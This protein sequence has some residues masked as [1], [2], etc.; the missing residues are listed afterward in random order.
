MSDEP[1]LPAAKP[2]TENARVIL[3]KGTLIVVNGV[4]TLKLEM[5]AVASG[6][7]AEIVAANLNPE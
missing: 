1:S 7:R 4:V 3:P 6:K 5:N 2:D